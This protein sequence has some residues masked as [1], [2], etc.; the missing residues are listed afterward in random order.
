MQP[1]LIIGVDIG[2]THTDA[3]LIDGA[4]KVLCTSK[5]LTTRDIVSGFSGVLTN[6]LAESHTSPAQVKSLFMGTTHATNAILEQKDLYKVGLI[7][8]AGHFPESLPPCCD[9]PEDLKASL[10]AGYETV[11]GGYECHGSA[12]TPLSLEEVKSAAIRLVDA[13]AESLAVVG[14][15]SPQK[16][17]QELEVKAFLQSHFGN[18]IS[19]TLSHL[20]GGIGFVEREN[21]TILNAALKKVMAHGFRDLDAATTALK[22]D[23]PLYITQ[24]NGTIIELAQAL[25]FP[26]L[27]ISAGPTNSF[28]GAGRLTG[29]TSA[30]VVDIGGTSTDIGLIKNGFPR[31]SLNTSHVGGVRLNFSMPDVL[32]IAIGGGSYINIE[33]KKP[34]I[35]PKSSGKQFRQESFCF[36]GRSLT[37]TD[38]AIKAG[39]EIHGADKSKVPCTEKEAHNVFEEVLKRVDKEIALF[40]G[41]DRDLPILLVGGGAQLFP[42]S[43]L[44]NRYQI[45]VHA[46][47]A[48][49][50]GAA[51]SEIS[52]VIDRVVS[53]QQRELVLDQLQLEAKRLAESRGADPESVRVVDLQIIPYHYVPNQ[54]ARVVVTAAGRGTT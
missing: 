24:N 46:N 5:T 32:S 14:V 37:L 33:G 29:V 1:S 51:L 4:G 9:W 47:V 19:I 30:I 28:I 18:A 8:L 27:T 41:E 43:F 17:D 12:I 31:R 36:G 2:G 49:A 10:F 42:P 34:Q 54:M 48:N 23:C 21:S 44:G 22:L 40:E 52:G 39:K 7:R 11:N 3:V 25:E 6:L 50:F 13:G 53:L 35:G 16:S 45:P 15:F 38:V 26:V 20:V